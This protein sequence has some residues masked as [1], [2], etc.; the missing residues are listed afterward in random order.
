MATLFLQDLGLALVEQTCPRR[1]QA[2]KK[3]RNSQAFS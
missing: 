3:A 1:A 2:I